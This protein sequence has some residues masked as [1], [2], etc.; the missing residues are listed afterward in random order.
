[1]ENFCLQNFYF[2]IIIKQVALIFWFRSKR[3][4][5]FSKLADTLISNKP[6]KLKIKHR[7]TKIKYYIKCNKIFLSLTN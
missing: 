5:S 1:M 7:K 6:V 4:C 3:T 2:S